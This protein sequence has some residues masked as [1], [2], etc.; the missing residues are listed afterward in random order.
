M[1]LIDFLL[2]DS[3]DFLISEP[4][5]VWSLAGWLDSRRPTKAPIDVDFCIE[6]VERFLL[7]I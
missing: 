3:P 4:N 1:N 2:P 6:I 5:T 7:Q